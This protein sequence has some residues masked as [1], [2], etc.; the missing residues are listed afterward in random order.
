MMKRI[1]I[2]GCGGSGKSTLARQLG[3]ILGIEVIHL[4]S[5][6]WKAG[7]V[8]SPKAEWQT[9][10]SELLKRDAWIMD[11]NYGGTLDVR[12]MQA[13]TIVFLDLP[14]VRCLFR[15]IKRRIQ[16][17]GNSRPDMA[18]GCPEKIDWEFLKW[19]W[20]YSAT[21]RPSVLEKIRQHANQTP[22]YILRT[23]REVGWFIQLVRDQSGSS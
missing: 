5:V 1:L 9:T 6:Y 17:R 20:N 11:G 8:E 22:T 15:V 21:S 10:V 4:D 2:I 18:A 19:I 7:W 14:R 16:Y 3:H 13:D 12:L 23:S